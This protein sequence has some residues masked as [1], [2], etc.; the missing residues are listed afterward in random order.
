MLVEIYKIIL[1][2]SPSELGLNHSY[3]LL[4]EP[5]SNEVNSSLL[6]PHL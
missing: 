1:D 4:C 5:E 6:F 2:L 3:H